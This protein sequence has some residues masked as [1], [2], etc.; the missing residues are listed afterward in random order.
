MQPLTVKKQESAG[1]TPG[2]KRQSTEVNRRKALLRKGS[3]SATENLVA[4]LKSSKKEQ[5]PEKKVAANK[6]LR[7]LL[8][9]QCLVISLAI[10]LSFLGTI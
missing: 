10:P 5:D 1:H 8:C 9:K 6:L 2:L 7:S 3:S 4:F